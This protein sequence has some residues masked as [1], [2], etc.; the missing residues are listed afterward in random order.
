MGDQ[1]PLTELWNSEET[2]H[3]RG[4]RV[5][6]IIVNE[7]QERH[8]IADRVGLSQPCRQRIDRNSRLYTK[9]TTQENW[10]PWELCLT[11]C[12][13]NRSDQGR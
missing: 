2:D 10:N 8:G 7:E 5:G 12:E 3:L 11:R 1:N 13:L 4:V 9:D 6:E